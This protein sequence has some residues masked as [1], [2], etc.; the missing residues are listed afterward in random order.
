MINK[1]GEGP[2]VQIAKVFGP[3]YPI[4]CGRHVLD[5]YLIAFLG[6][7]NFGNKS[8][9]R[10]ISFFWKSSIFYV[11]FINKDIVLQIIVSELLLLNCLD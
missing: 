3:L 9:M 11:D 4:A 5:V 6:D 1:Y 7:W 2:A 10:V 8:A